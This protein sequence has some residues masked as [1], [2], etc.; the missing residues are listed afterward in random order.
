MKSFLRIADETVV[1]RWTRWALMLLVAASFALRS[2]DLEAKSLWTDEGLTVSR[3]EQPISLVFKNK[4][5][6]PV[7]PNYYD[8]SRVDE[9][10][11]P[12]VHPPLYFLLMHLWIR[13]AGQSEFVLRF[14]SVIASMLV[15]PLLFS[16]AS[17][18]L[19][20]E[21]GLW[22]ALLAATSPFYTWHA[23][24]ARMYAWV[25]LFS[26][27][28]VY[29]LLPLLRETAKPRHYLS[30]LV[31]TSALLYTHYTG[32]LL[33]AFEVAI[34]GVYQSR[35]GIRLGPV[36]V[37]LAVA[38]LVLIPLAPYVRRVLDLSLFGFVSRPLPILL[39][40]AWSYFSLGISESLIR[41]LWQTAPFL[42]LFVVGALMIGVRR[43][44]EAWMVSLGYL[45]IPLLMF[46][47]ISYFKPNYMNPRHLLIISP[48]WELVMAQGLATL[49]RRFWPGLVLLLGLSLFFRG[50]ANYKIFS[51]H[52]LWK[53]DIRGAIKYIEARAQPGDAIVL[54]DPVIRLTVDYYYDGP[55]PLASIPGFAES[56]EQK[57][58]DEFARWSQRY[59]RIWFLYGPPPVHFP[60]NLLPE[61]ADSHLFKVSQREFEAIWTYVGVAA[62]DDEPPVL[63]A[64]PVEAVSTDVVWSP[65]R[66]VGFHAQEMMQNDTGSFE[67]YW[68]VDEAPSD[69]PL[70]LK[71]R[72]LDDTGMAWYEREDEVLP[73]Y[74]PSEWPADR[75]IQT[76]FPLSLPADLPPITYT[77]QVAPVGFG[78]PQAVGEILVA[79]SGQGSSGECPS[80]RF[81]DDIVLL[82]GELG[83]HVFRAGNPLFASLT[84]FTNHPIDDDYLVRVR[85]VDQQGLEVT[86]DEVSPTAAG[87]P[88]S[89]WVPG[90]PVAGRLILPIPIDLKGGMYRVQISLVNGETGRVF[91]A[92]N[93]YRKRDWLSL[94][95]VEVEAWPL[96]TE[97]PQQVDH[98]LESVEVAGN[99][100]LLGYE[101]N[102]EQQTLNLTLYWQAE[103]SLEED[104]HVF[105]HV[106]VPDEPPLADAGGV[107]ANWTRPTKSWRPG[108]VIVDEHAIPL[109]NVPPGRY[110]L[111]TGFYEPD[112][113]Q[114][115]ETVVDGTVVLGGYI[116]LEEMRVE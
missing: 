76:D 89:E 36:L 75:I 102:Q 30:Y 23:Q 49:R 43:R 38:A 88:T 109:V 107:P 95:T 7:E 3:A 60:N 4:N 32:F 110:A 57:V 35:K 16:L 14:P 92:R 113:G 37:F 2:H 98:R 101:S 105:V 31:A 104:Y 87:Y 46:H 11:T 40:E 24:E 112:T 73:F 47:V 86:R 94:G 96:R 61:W 65:L 34:Y 93:W 12:D 1:S 28:S 9:V 20:R 44:Q 59:D 64:L 72:L 18:L 69:R 82:D 33:L 115:P 71:V 114:R 84:W 62:Y 42:A 13:V 91:P 106:G 53:D 68:Q 22:A 10:A 81:G 58:V 6:I 27:A 48:A 51:S 108:E 74:P 63:D 5:L 99:V 70:R 17:A 79:R 26:V 52:S 77:V 90:A 100:R 116:V 78:N 111:V 54:H 21:A 55:Y 85:L 25:I 19:S 39:A 15:L 50:R 56:N 66:L 29:T 67:L 8:G 103:D 97:L 45:G 41:P 83:S 80:A